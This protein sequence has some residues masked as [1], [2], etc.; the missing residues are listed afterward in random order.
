MK[1]I[2][3]VLSVIMILAMLLSLTAVVASAAGTGSI[4]INNAYEGEVYSIVKLFNATIG[5]DDAINYTG[6]IPEELKAYFQADAAGNI[7]ATDAAKDSSGAL[8]AEAVN[9]LTAWAK[10]Q[11]NP[12]TKT[13]DASKV[14]VFDGLAYGYYVV[15][16]TMGAAVSV[17]SVNPQVALNDKNQPDNIRKEVNEDS[18]AD[19][20]Y[21][22]SASAQIGQEVPFKLTVTARKNTVNLVAHDNM[23]A[24]LTLNQN[25]FVVKVKGEAN[26]LPANAYTISYNDQAAGD[27]ANCTFH[28]TFTADYLKTISADTDIEITYSAILNENAVIYDKANPN[29]AWLTFGNSQRSSDSVVNVYTYTFDLVKTDSSNKLLAGAE[30]EL[31][32][33]ENGGNKIPLVKVDNNTW[34]IATAAEREAEGFESAKI[35]TN[36]DR[37]IKIVGVDCDAETVYWLQET[38]APDGYNILIGRVEVKMNPVDDGTGSGK[39]VALNLDATMN[40]EDSKVWEKGGVHVENKKGSV[41]PETGGMGTTMFIVFGSLTALCAAVVLVARKKAAGYR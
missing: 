33:A 23:S 15:L 6:T 16:S 3:K 10:A 22:E 30:F 38:A 41:L 34:R 35:I 25:S 11:P 4:T 18:D 37:P 19:D 26:P 14:V 24:G 32:D 9:A 7:T 8:S 28:V 31:Y 27:S 29:T 21:G 13:A 36:A 5:A 39:K 2:T 12:V 20:A 17:D 1:K 40:A